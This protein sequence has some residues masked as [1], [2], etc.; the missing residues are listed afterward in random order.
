[1]RKPIFLIGA[2]RSGSTF[3]TAV[4]NSHPAVHVTNEARIFV[5]LQH[6]LG[7]LVHDRR[8]V[9]ARYAA[10]FSAVLLGHM[11]SVADGLYLSQAVREGKDARGLRWLGEKY[12]HYADPYEN[13]GVNAGC[14][15]LI[16]RVYPDA[17]YIHIH[18]HP[19][20]SV[21]SITRKGWLAP[22]DAALVWSAISEASMQH[23]NRYAARSLSLSWWDLC[24]APE[25]QATRIARFLSLDDATS[26]SV[27][28]A[29]NAELPFEVSAPVTRPLAD[30][31]SLQLPPDLQ[32]E[33]WR[34]AGSAA[35]A[36]GYR[37]AS[38]QPDR[39]SQGPA[40]P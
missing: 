20:Q 21:A 10:D 38:T 13:G 24:T 1:M 31:G 9:E 3:L 18:R 30:L 17:H 33:V 32:D 36:L 7:H 8:M 5:L 35:E 19:F 4:L 16:D 23:C 37:R 39:P 34:V 12:P 14:M 25:E 6:V 27:T 29:R 22:T 26:L 15:Q 11:R 40:A 28:L 2:P